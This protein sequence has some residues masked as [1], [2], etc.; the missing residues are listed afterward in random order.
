MGDLIGIVAIAIIYLCVMKSVA[1]KRQ[2]KQQNQAASARRKGGKRAR[3]R[4]ASFAQAF[5]GDVQAEKKQPAARRTVTDTRGMPGALAAQ[6]AVSSE[7]GCGEAAHAPGMHLHEVTQA[8]MMSAGEGE[9]PC[10]A[11]RAQRHAMPEESALGMADAAPDTQDNEAARE[12][13]RGVILSEILERPCE[14]RARLMGRRR[15]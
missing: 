2:A 10:H 9:D 15:M 8:Q 3:E 6:A 14:R 12:L 13:L 7:G 11:G 4:K 5:D 1:K